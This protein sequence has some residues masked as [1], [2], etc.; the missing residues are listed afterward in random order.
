MCMTARR[1]LPPEMVE[2]VLETKRA[3]DGDDASDDA[4]KE[5][6]P[7]CTS[8]KECLQQKSQI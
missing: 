6:W 7:C 4:A 1:K 2:L 8:T 5:R 3:N